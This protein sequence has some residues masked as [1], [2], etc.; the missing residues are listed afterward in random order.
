MP[1]FV[2]KANRSLVGGKGTPESRAGDEALPDDSRT[3]LGAR[4]SA[5]GLPLPSDWGSSSPFCL[6]SSED[7]HAEPREHLAVRSSVPVSVSEHEPGHSFASTASDL[8]TQ[9]PHFSVRGLPSP[10]HSGHCCG[11]SEVPRGTGPSH[12]F[13]GTG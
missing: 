3:A 13:Q 12:F 5:K 7:G 10:V 11:I 1:E 6:L 4:A 8:K 9:N 2:P